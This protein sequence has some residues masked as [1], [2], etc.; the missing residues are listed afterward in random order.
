MP[1]DHPKDKKMKETQS[2]KG[3]AKAVPTAPVVQ[4]APPDAGEWTSKPASRAPSPY[5]S[6]GFMGT[7]QNPDRDWLISHDPGNAGKLDNPWIPLKHSLGMYT[8]PAFPEPREG[9]LGSEE[10]DFTRS[11]KAYADKPVGT[12]LEKAADEAW[13]QRKRL[14]VAYW[15]KYD[16][17]PGTALHDAVRGVV[18]GDLFV[19]EHGTWGWQTRAFQTDGKKIDAE[20]ARRKEYEATRGKE[21]STSDDTSES[22]L[23]MPPARGR[24]PKPNPEAP[25]AAEVKKQV[26]GQQQLKK[27]AP[28]GSGNQ[29]GGGGTSG[30]QGKRKA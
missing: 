3:Q 22:G 11:F 6:S 2:E 15:T 5:G 4:S 29:R 24:G 8:G 21:S 13:E 27:P 16:A 12:D 17:V 25:K 30:G 1:S 14:K 9:F 26:A 18:K 7:P 10:N 20:I 23:V 19:T 28:S